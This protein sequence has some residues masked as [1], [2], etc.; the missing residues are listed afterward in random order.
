MPSA[1]MRKISSAVGRTRLFASS[2]RYCSSA[3]A[4][5]AAGPP[6]DLRAVGAE[7]R[8]AVVAGGGG[9]ALRS[10]RL[11]HHVEVEVAVADGG[12][13]QLAAAAAPRRLRV[14]PRRLGEAPRV[15]RR[16]APLRTG[17]SCRRAPTRSPATGRAGPG[18]PPPRRAWRRRRCGRLRASRSSRRSCAPGPWTPGVRRPSPGPS[19]TAGRTLPRAASTGR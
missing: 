19:R 17:H 6:H 16:P 1:F 7:E 5:G 9:Q 2:E 4:L 15:K 3:G 11:V 12:E 18:R 8:A 13:H 10:A 14:V